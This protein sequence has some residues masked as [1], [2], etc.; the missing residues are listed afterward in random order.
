M[1]K[2]ITALAVTAAL[3]A[4]SQASVTINFGMGEM[5][6]STGTTTAFPSGGLINLLALD[7][8]TWSSAFPD[9]ALSLSSNTSSWTL[10][11]TTLVG[12]IANDDSGGAGVTGGAFNY[13]YSGSFGAGDQLLIVA[14]PGLTLAS[15]SPGL[16]RAGFFFRTDSILDG[17]D[18]AY[19]APADGGT[20]SLATYT[21]GLGG[22]VANNQFTSGA[23]AAGGQGF[24]TV[25]E[26]STYALLSLAGLALGGY[27]VR[28]RRRA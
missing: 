4:S 25:P 5:Y 16:G 3:A 18:I 9:L 6:S 13:S 26:P 17:S 22:S 24:T 12:Q 10:P 7:S 8:G 27:A 23:G 20:Y 11:G 1:K 2:Y 21:V 15:S 28:R 19:A 14:Y